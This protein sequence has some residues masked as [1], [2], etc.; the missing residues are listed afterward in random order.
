MRMS[1]NTRTRI[2]VI[3]PDGRVIFDSRDN[4]E[5]MENHRDRPEVKSA[6]GGN[7]WPQPRDTAIR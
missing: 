5:R 1:Q 4:P 6:L 2:T 7:S 3:L